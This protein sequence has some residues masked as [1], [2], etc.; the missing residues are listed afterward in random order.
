MENI[1]ILICSSSISARTLSNH[2]INLL[3][4]I[5]ESRLLPQTLLLFKITFLVI[6]STVIYFTS[7]SSILYVDLIVDFL[8]LFYH[9][10][11]AEE[12]S[13]SALNNQGG[14]IFPL[15]LFL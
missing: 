10:S 11:P 5:R 4:F 12:A 6:I 14:L 13:Y 9:C 8:S 7:E 3:H 1:L 2:F 15:F